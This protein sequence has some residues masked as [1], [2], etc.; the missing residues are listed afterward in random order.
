MDRS[1]AINFLKELLRNYTNMPPEAV[2]F[3]Q[4]TGYEGFTVRIK[5]TLQERDKEIIRNIAE[6]CCLAVKE[7]NDQ[8]LIFKL[9]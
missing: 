5:D 4:L 7:E 9:K 6:K 1:E 8:V 3:E 2:S